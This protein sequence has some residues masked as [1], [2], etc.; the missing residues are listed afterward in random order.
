MA[1]LA[2]LRR[3]F[4]SQVLGVSALIAILIA[5]GCGSSNG[6]GGTSAS[7]SLSAVVASQGDFS[8]GEQGAASTITVSNTGTAA[9]SGTVTVMDPP[10]GFVVTTMS[11]ANW[12]CTVSTTTCTYSAP[13]A[14]GQVERFRTIP[15][16]ALWSLPAKLSGPL[17]LFDLAVF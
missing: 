1:K 13:V 2:Q 10:A 15:Y 11:G 3:N 7:P 5:P 6:G 9:T 8:S 4:L 16:W 12:T 17:I 14:T